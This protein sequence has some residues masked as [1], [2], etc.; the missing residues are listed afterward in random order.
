MSENIPCGHRGPGFRLGGDLQEPTAAPGRDF[1][2]PG[3]RSEERGLLTVMR[4]PSAHS[5]IITPPPVST[6]ENLLVSLEGLGW[7]L[8]SFPCSQRHDLA[9]TPDPPSQGSRHRGGGALAELTGIGEQLLIPRSL[10]CGDTW[11]WS[12]ETSQPLPLRLPGKRGDLPEQRNQLL[13]L[14]HFR[15]TGV[16]WGSPLPCQS[17]QVELPQV[18]ALWGG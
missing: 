17:L 15:G 7:Q 13:Q 12:L 11:V 18:L 1:I 9:Q 8:E 2:P 16:P 5:Q 10:I 6:Q 4:Q 14:L 3:V